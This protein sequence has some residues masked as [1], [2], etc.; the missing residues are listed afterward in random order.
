MPTQPIPST[1]ATSATTG[2]DPQRVEDALR[3]LAPKWTTGF[4]HTIAK[5]GPEM[6]VRDLTQYFPPSGQPN[7]SKRLADMHKS[8]LVARDAGFD[9]TTPYRLTDRALTL[10]PLYRALAQWSSDHI[11]RTLR[12]RSDRIE[13][14][15]GRLQLL[16]T[17][18]VVHLLSEHRSM[19][20]TQL[21][22][23]VGVYEQLMVPRPRSSASSRQ[24]WHAPT[25]AARTSS[26]PAVPAAGST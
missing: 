12:G 20:Y 21:A 8:G 13:G 3:R 6:R 22:D 23:A 14:T 24:P 25:P 7:I 19:R 18:K 15:L 10:G 2:V 26:C 9:R 16:N 5:Y 1:A 17:T 4:V 11:D